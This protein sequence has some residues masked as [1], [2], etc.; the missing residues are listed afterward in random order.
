MPVVEK[1]MSDK[2]ELQ[3]SV[4]LDLGAKY[5]GVAIAS[6]MNGEPLSKDR[7]QACTIVMPDDG[8]KMV[9]SMTNRRA[10]RHRLRGAKRFDMARRLCFLAI[11]E[12]MQRKGVSLTAEE[13]RRMKEAVGGLLRRRGYSRV[14][15]EVEWSVC[16]SAP[17]ELLLEQPALKGVFTELSPISEQFASLADAEIEQLDS[18]LKD[19]KDRD[20][21][22]LLKSLGYEAS[23][24]EA[25]KDAF[26][27]IK[28]A[29][30]TFCQQKIMGHKPR[31]EY[32]RD[33]RVAIQGDSRLAKVVEAFGG[34]NRFHALIGNISNLQL[35]AERWYFND[36]EMA[37]EGDLWKPRE[38]KKALVR[39]F[40]YFHPGSG[41]PE[42][43]K[44]KEA[45]RI[46][47][48]IK[49]FSESEDILETLCTL[50]PEK[51]I[52]PYE[53]QN[54]RHP[55]VDQTLYLNPVALTSRY[56]QAW[57]VWARKFVEKD[58]QLA[59]DLDEIL[60]LTDRKSRLRINKREPLETRSYYWSYILQRA[61]DRSGVLDSYG[62]R[63]Q[64]TGRLVGET[65]EKVVGLKSLIGPQ[66]IGAFL[67]FARDY[68]KE[69]S[70]AKAGLW[71]PDEGN[72]LERADIH[73]PMKKQML[74]VLVGNVLQEK[75]LGRKFIEDI[76]KKNDKVKGS[77][78]VRS[79]C[80]SIELLR[81]KRGNA[82][83]VDY[84]N[85]K[86]GRTKGIDK[87]IAV[88]PEKVE[89]VSDFIA[90]K[91]GVSDTQKAKF[92]N[93]YS[94]S[95][96]YTLIETDPDG[97]S[98]CTKAAQFENAWR[99]T[100]V[101]FEGKDGM[102]ELSAQCS[103]LPVDSARP[104]DGVVR[105]MVDRVS[106]EVAKQI[107]E[108]VEKR[109][110]FTDG[111]VIVPILIEQNRF[112][113]SASLATIKKQTGKANVL[114]KDLD[115]QAKDWEEKRERIARA[116]VNISP[117][118]GK[119]LLAGEGEYDH[120]LPRSWTKERYGMVFDAEP[121]LIYVSQ[122]DN[123]RKKDRTYTLANIADNYLK[124][125]FDTSD[126][127]A[128]RRKIEE[129][130]AAL[131][132]SKELSLGHW[133]YLEPI[134]RHCIRMALFLGEDSRAR[135]AVLALLKTRYSTAV[136]GTQK[137]FLKNLEKKLFARLADWQSR[138]RN[139][140]TLQAAQVSSKDAG[141]LRSEWAEAFPNRAKQKNPQPVASHSMD[142]FCV[143]ASAYGSM[144]VGEESLLSAQK[145]EDLYPESCRLTQV[146]S[147]LLPEKLA[148]TEGDAV[149]QRKSVASQNLFKEGIYS[150]NFLPLFTKKITEEENGLFIGFNDSV[151]GKSVSALRV[152][153]NRPE[154]LLE[155]LRPVLGR[156]PI[157]DLSKHV[158]YPIDNRKAQQVL[159][160]VANGPADDTE[161]RLA[162]ILQGLSYY[163]VKEP[164]DKHLIDAKGG[165]Q[166][167]EQAVGDIDGKN[168]FTIKIG[169]SCG[170]LFK[171]DGKIVSPLFKEWSR[172]YDLVVN[173]PSKKEGDGGKHDS[174]W[175]QPGEQCTV[176]ELNK[177]VSE[178]WKRPRGE[179]VHAATHRS[180]SLPVVASV[181]GAVAVS[182]SAPTGES[183]CQIHA[184]NAQVKGFA[185]S[186]NGV[187]D[188]T[189]DLPFDFLRQKNL[190]LRGS[191]YVDH[192]GGFAA[193]TDWRQ[194]LEGP[195]R[196]WVCPR[197][198][199]RFYIRVETTCEQFSSWLK[200]A[201]N[202]EDK[203][204]LADP[205]KL[206]SQ[207][208]LSKPKEFIEAMPQEVQAVVSV[209]RGTLFF[210][211][212]GETVTFRYEAQG[213]AANVKDAFNNPIRAN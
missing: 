100:Q 117:Y 45:A 151:N 106:W 40:Q 94:L 53:D 96:L 22:K 69:V 186:D 197:Q 164:L 73:P 146:V 47:E 20:F 119:P 125:L 59:G 58:Q 44:Q 32:L 95:Q 75:E 148:L 171:A 5:T 176:D 26:G 90:K 206:K 129:R 196:V 157:G 48:V 71:L 121:N 33:I 64:A 107:A 110:S 101:P 97:F 56:G 190:A 1:Y 191:V 24:A 165:F 4:G 89:K 113:F 86:A 127:D 74:D 17:I 184:V 116:S 118:S 25:A 61:L 167:K 72:L 19:E 130:V 142:A 39:A 212:V 124:A 70:Q 93:P 28:T 34:T 205:W 82:F 177:R 104:I 76:W 92:A 189:K 194:V 170:K 161:K 152:G 60:A 7:M 144:F 200:N 67:S 105:R 49:I 65:N 193:I 140:V 21:E 169:V 178:F 23:A 2:N 163:T 145:L 114:K 99:M 198:K 80:K 133:D 109:A 35:R 188:W 210:E 15:T 211:R 180:Y 66:H 159:A 43:D 155:V 172:I 68:Y 199:S 54:N 11:G 154:E 36:L 98:T 150:E 139:T 123:Q 85:A 8:D 38:L 120:I 122:E 162:Q 18:G 175:I 13:S 51:T 192:Q 30:H 168:G 166:P 135:K 108:T 201:I 134:D 78:T 84:N 31:G 77:S 81:K 102:K 183:V 111:N 158:V 136:N 103:R 12:Q 207:L 9:L 57:T 29:A 203:E 112:E 16:D 88:L 132:D 83:N 153:G 147:K 195:A 10:A 14:E 131:D 6:R 185:T 156:Q 52:P 41:V 179:R 204:V 55:Q 128:V 37:A 149:A 27:I 3:V 208:K 187:V 137:W 46:A 143:L 181:S 213:A 87:E 42:K 115:R 126:R 62:V 91:L 209:P 138:T 202:D 63:A 173:G 79:I 141:N 50:P 174:P 182:R 160:R